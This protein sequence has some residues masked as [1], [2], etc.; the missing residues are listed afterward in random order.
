MAVAEF[1]DRKEVVTWP[2]DSG[3][4]T[5]YQERDPVELTVKGNIPRYASGVLYRT[6]PL[7]YKTETDKGNT[8]AANHW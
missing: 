2:N 5:A 3:F 8:Y 6:G 1:E 4:D 7:G